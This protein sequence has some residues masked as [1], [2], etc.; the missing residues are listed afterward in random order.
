MTDAHAAERQKGWP[1][2]A[3][4]AEGRVMSHRQDDN[5]YLVDSASPSRCT[6][7]RYDG[8]AHRRRVQ[9]GI[10]L[11]GSAPVARLGTLTE[12]R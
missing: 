10:E 7:R 9:S 2:E 11:P 12:L 8:G 3:N 6:G 4:A 1:I 5:R